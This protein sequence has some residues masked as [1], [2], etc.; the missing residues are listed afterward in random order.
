MFLNCQ[1]CKER[2]S[3]HLKLLTDSSMIFAWF[4]NHNDQRLKRHAFES[5]C[6]VAL[7]VVIRSAGCCDCRSG[8][9]SLCQ[10]QLVAWLGAK[11]RGL[12]MTVFVIDDEN[13][14]LA[15]FEDKVAV[16]NNDTREESDASSFASVFREIAIFRDA[17]PAGL[18]MREITAH[19]IIIQ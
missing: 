3:R 16:I 4:L 19:L 6:F 7:K 9:Q 13:Q 17:L 2:E 10:I 8:F 1:A 12:F 14:L 18:M 11:K 15:W 5:A